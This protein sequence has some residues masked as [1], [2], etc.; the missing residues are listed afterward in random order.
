MIIDDLLQNVWIYMI[1]NFSQ[2]TVLVFIP[3]ITLLTI[4]FSV[5]LLEVLI[6]FLFPTLIAK[7]KIQPK[8]KNTYDFIQHTTLYVLGTFWI[9]IF[10][11]YYFSF[12]F[13]VT[14]LGFSIERE[15]PKW[16][17]WVPQLIAF[18][19]IEDFFHYFFHRF[20]HMK[21]IY[22]WIHYK[23][24]EFD[25]P[26]AIAATYAHPAEV[27]ILGFCTM[28]GPMIFVPHFFV[29]LFWTIWRQMIALETHLGYDLPISSHRLLPFLCG[30][31][32]HHDFHHQYRQSNF[33]STFI[34]W[35]KVFQTE[36]KEWDTVK[37]MKK[38]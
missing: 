15:L 32:K 14:H 25:A 5:G 28:I 37:D 11:N 26:T 20:L 34:I 16:T 36:S 4:Y 3:F 8:K 2:T 17:T 23:H 22:H 9:F 19:F 33:A 38:A 31:A 21:F 24:H 6:E 27:V 30:G 12:N 29:F 10:P 18:V 1:E 13:I 7:Y 35:D